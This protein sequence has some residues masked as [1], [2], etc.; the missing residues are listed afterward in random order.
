MDITRPQIAGV[1]ADIVPGGHFAR[2]TRQDKDRLRVDDLAG[3][4]LKHLPDLQL[5]LLDDQYAHRYFLDAGTKAFMTE[6]VR[7]FSKYGP[8]F[9]PLPHPSW[10]SAIW[11]QKNPWFEVEVIPDLRNVVRK[12]VQ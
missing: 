5:T 10:R 11:M 3:S 2:W 9:F 1:R 12:L 7:V 4:L 8:Q 6:T